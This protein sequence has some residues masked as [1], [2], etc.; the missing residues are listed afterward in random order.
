MNSSSSHRTPPLCA[1]LVIALALGCAETGVPADP[2]ARDAGTRHATDASARRVSTS[3]LLGLG[4]VGG[5]EGELTFCERDP[6]PGRVCCGGSQTCVPAGVACPEAPHGA[7]PHACRTNG[8]C[9]AAE[10]CARAD[11]ISLGTCAPRPT[12]CAPDAPVCGC[13]A[14][15]YPNRCAAITADVPIRYEGACA[16][17]PQ[18][19][20]LRP[21][22]CDSEHPFA[23][24]PLERCCFRGLNAHR[25]V[26]RYCAGCC[27]DD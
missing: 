3:A 4:D 5:A 18:P 19:P 17:L 20:P 6:C 25:C 22:E 14:V 9:L 27:T 2:D 11:C 24:G 8:D 7:G 13:N 26:S 21:G 15:T 16:S 12:E 23:C 1:G 10:Y